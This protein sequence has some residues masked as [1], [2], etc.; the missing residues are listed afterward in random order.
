MKTLAKITCVIVGA[1]AAS[2]TLAD[3]VG[4]SPKADFKSNQLTIPCVKVSNLSASADGKYF[5]VT[6]VRRG[7]SYNYELTT[8]EPE[9]STLC[10]RLASLAEYEDE[11]LSP[12]PTTPTTGSP[13]TGTTTPGANTPAATTMLAQCE[14]RSN[15]SKVT[16]KG[17]N[18]AAGQYY[19]SVT[20]GT[21]TV[22]STNQTITGNEVEIKF[23][24]D[25]GDIAAGAIALTADFI[26]GA[27]ITA[28]LFSAGSTT[29]LASVDA[30]CLVK[31]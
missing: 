31:K 28:K 16:V 23:D 13:T 2:T 4:G 30:A 9:D 1:I 27:K 29:A 10:E 6:L 19:A 3:K 21:K 7:N 25:A 26:Q 22:Q 11:D 15:R 18:L 17:K 24:S 8:A 14:V 5:D 12:Q 20:S